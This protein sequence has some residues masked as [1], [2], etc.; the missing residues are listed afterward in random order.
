MTA[1]TIADGTTVKNGT[2]KLAGL[3]RSRQNLERIQEHLSAVEDAV[4]SAVQAAEDY[5]GA[6]EDPD[7]SADEREEIWDALS[8]ALTELAEVQP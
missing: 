8:S 3:R 2:S 7:C 6:L 5:E 1:T 4:A